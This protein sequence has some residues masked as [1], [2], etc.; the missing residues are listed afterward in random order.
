[1][2][3]DNFIKPAERMRL[4]PEYL[5]GRLN[6]AKAS[7]RRKGR[8]VIDFGMGN[9]DQPADEFIV[10]KMQAVIHDV[11]AHRYSDAKGIPHLLKAVAHH[12]KAYYD[13]KLDPDSEIIATIGS[14]EGLSHLTLALLGFGDRCLVP[15]P[16]FPVHVWSAVIAGAEPLMFPLSDD[17]GTF[18]ASMEKVMAGPGPKPKLLFLNFPHNPTA[19]TVTLDFMQQVVDYCRSNS[20]F[21]IHDFAYKD[22]TFDGYTAPSIMQVEGASELAVE[23]I[24]MSKS[25]NMAG[26]RCGFCVGNPRVIKLLGQIKAYYDY[27]LFTP[28][29][30]A[31]IAALK[32]PRESVNKVARKYEKRRNV[33]I[34][35]LTRGG[36]D[37][38]RPRG[39]MFVWA[40]LPD[41]F[42]PGGS[43]KFSEILLD[44]A[45][46]LVSPG[47]GFGE[48]GEGFVRM[49]LVEN[50]E[51]IRQATRQ[52]NRVLKDYRV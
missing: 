9:P 14:K 41:K 38:P 36:W 15:E 3:D 48:A 46:V 43:L 11:K 19:T 40:G 24:T 27:G 44:E 29:Q 42:L 50:T 13:V 18:I 49:S 6:A 39:A 23:F 8:D 51:R 32:Q 21:I 20:I 16:A 30:V 1:M 26:W 12:Y 7:M 37:I 45:E 2:A 34:E 52:I 17:A 35:G 5:F 33:L 10:D 31:S 28:I 25:Y 4:L 47:I 22:I